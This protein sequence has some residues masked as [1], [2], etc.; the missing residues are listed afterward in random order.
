MQTIH[1]R[2][3][4]YQLTGGGDK[5]QAEI[6][7]ETPE[8]GIELVHIR[9]NAEQPVRRQSS[10]CYGSSRLSIFTASGTRTDTATAGYRRT[11]RQAIRAS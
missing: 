6:V 11:G 5:L 10:G 2:S 1:Q 7:V 3:H 8:D 4:R 9:L